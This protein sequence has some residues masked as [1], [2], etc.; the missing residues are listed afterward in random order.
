MREL[1]FEGLSDNDLFCLRFGLCPVCL[2]NVECGGS[3]VYGGAAM[4]SCFC[5]DCRKLYWGD[6]DYLGNHEEYI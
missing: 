2:G 5:G 1:R 4:A 6:F 3:F